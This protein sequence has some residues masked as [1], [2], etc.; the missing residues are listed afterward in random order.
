[1][2]EDMDN[3]SQTSGVP[4]AVFWDFENCPP[5][6]GSKGAPVI[7]S[8][9]EVLLQFGWIRQIQAYGELKL[10][11]ERLR[12]ELQR[13]GVHLIDVHSVRKDAADKM[14]I[15]DMLLFAV[16]NP[17][18]KIII[19]IS[20]D[21]DYTYPLAKLRQRGYEV[22]LVVPPVG[23]HPTLKEQADRIIEWYDIVR[24]GPGGVPS[25]DA[26]EALKFDPLISILRQLRDEGAD[27][28]TLVD[29]SQLLAEKYPARWL[30][31]GK[32]KL[33]NYIEEATEAGLVDWLT[34]G[35]ERRIRLLKPQEEIIA[36]DETLISEESRFS[37]LIVVLQKA[38]SEGIEDFVLYS[39]VGSQ[40]RTMIPNWQEH[41]GVH[42]LKDYIQEAETA[43]IVV[44]R[45]EGLDHYVKLTTTT[46]DKS[47]MVYMKGDKELD[48]LERTLDELQEDLIIPYEKNVINRMKEIAKGESYEGDFDIQKTPFK[49]Y[50]A[51]LSAAQEQ[52]DIMVEGTE[53]YRIFFKQGRRYAGVDPNDCSKDSFSEE[54]WVALL[55]H[56]T[57]D[58]EMKAKGRYSLAKQVKDAGVKE[59]EDLRLG[60]LVLMIQLAANRGWFEFKGSWWKI[61]PDLPKRAEEELLLSEA[62]CLERPS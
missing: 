55:R 29:L 32:V 60:E 51:L 53:P 34:D 2:M 10:V 38:R 35:Q 24:E 25:R 61:D 56:F 20:G 31:L 19:L 41:L 21:Q 45:H 13:S 27:D 14:I 39:W 11:P 37:P 17:P 7:N 44:T 49:T 6:R 43:G 1:M 50:D 28:P 58:I 22:I 40:L 5:P 9:R 26:R 23:A 52:R 62:G 59:L 18:P 36:A 3:S 8:L 15:S 4:M 57:G 54:Q 30:R 12:S 46:A 47:L 42:Q 33:S 48:L 16:D